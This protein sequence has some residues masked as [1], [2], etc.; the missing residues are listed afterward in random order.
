MARQRTVVPRS[1]RR[2]RRFKSCHPDQWKRS[3]RPSAGSAK[4]NAEGTNEK[5]RAS[6]HFDMG[7][8]GPDPLRGSPGHC[9]RARARRRRGCHVSSRTRAGR[10]QRCWQQP[11]RRRS[12][13]C[14]P[15][16][17]PGARRRQPR[18]GK[19]WRLRMSRRTRGRA[20]PAPPGLAPTP[21]RRVGMRARAG[22]G[23]RRCRCGTA[24]PEQRSRPA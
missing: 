8:R 23:S 2:G 24:Q 3:F 6:V 1:G 19:S 4:R 9:W 15:P 16:R 12:P 13:N 18:P 20:A 17:G 7:L 21:C 5:S 22:R 10:A 14:T 11:N